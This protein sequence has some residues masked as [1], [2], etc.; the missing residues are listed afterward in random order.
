MTGLG[1]V[2]PLPSRQSLLDARQVRDCVRSLK[3]VAG[4]MPA[5]DSRKLLNA[6]VTDLIYIAFVLHGEYDGR[7]R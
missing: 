6:T 3:G 5:C 2:R 4:R 7:Y 1:E